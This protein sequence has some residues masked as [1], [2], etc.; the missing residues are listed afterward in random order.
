MHTRPAFQVAVIAGLV[1][2]GLAYGLPVVVGFVVVA[3]IWS[4]GHDNIAVLVGLVFIVFS[5]WW[6]VGGS[7]ERCAAW[8]GRMLLG[9]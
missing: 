2:A 1:L 4:S 5:S 3:L 9:K 8:V 7:A 6:F